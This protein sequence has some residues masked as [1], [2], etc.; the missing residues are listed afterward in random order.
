[1]EIVLVQCMRSVA[2]LKLTVEN[3]R[4]YTLPAQKASTGPGFAALVLYGEHVYIYVHITPHHQ[5]RRGR[6]HRQGNKQ[7]R[8]RDLC[9]LACTVFI[10]V[11]CYLSAAV[12]WKDTASACLAYAIL[13]V[14]SHL[15]R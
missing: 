9:F 12:P 7:A 4:F 10:F 8:Q 6:R 15:H 13:V 14:G 11:M 1:M 2:T 3:A 5:I